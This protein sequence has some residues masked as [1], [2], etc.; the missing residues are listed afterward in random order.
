MEMYVALARAG[1][2]AVPINFRL[3]A[4]EIEYIATHCEARAFI[5]QHAL[6]DRVEPIR[7]NLGIVPDGFIH[8]GRRQR[9]AGWQSYEALIARASSNRPDT[10]VRPEDTWALMYTSG[11]TGKRRCDPQSTRAAALISL[12]TALD[13]GFARG[14]TAAPGDADVPRELAVFLVHVHLSRRRLRGR[15][16]D[17]ISSRRSC[18]ARSPRST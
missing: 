7:A 3:V 14:N 5:V 2:V 4:A 16:L 1:L 15:R 8:F 6:I 12:V 9:R 17:R 11:T 13:M 10:Q 18:C